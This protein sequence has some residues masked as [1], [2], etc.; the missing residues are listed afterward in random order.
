MDE[1]TKD[2]DEA[3]KDIDEA[4]KDTDE[5]SQDLDDGYEKVVLPN[6]EQL[7]QFLLIAK[8]EKKTMAKFAK[9]CNTYPTFFSRVIHK[10][11][12]KP[13]DKKLIKAIAENSADPEY[14]TYDRLMRANGYIPVGE[15]PA[16]AIDR[17]EG[18]TSR[19]EHKRFV[20]SARNLIVDKL[21]AQ[22]EPIIVYS[23][24]RNHFSMLGGF[25]GVEERFG[26]EQSKH[27]IRGIASQFAIKMQGKKPDI[28][29]F[30]CI[31]SLSFSERAVKTQISCTRNFLS[32][33]GMLF[34]KDNFEPEKRVKHTFIFRDE[35]EY[36]LVRQ[37]LS[38][39]KVNGDISFILV[40][41][42]DENMKYIEEY[43]LPRAD[44]KKNK[45]VFED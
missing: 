5:E 7:A 14:I 24:N 23:R 20:E 17:K 29:N 8:G 33:Y 15:D 6:F 44:G 10:T 27:G 19:L 12:G 3:T 45:S 35:V 22:D 16:N 34:L 2:K 11:I 42:E 31:Y 39:I 4:T 32:D 9:E 18:E 30:I 21:Y 1:A 36:G 13:L 26:L 40:N 37:C 28:W 41:D 43:T 25:S 38:D